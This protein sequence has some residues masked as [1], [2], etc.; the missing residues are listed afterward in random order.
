MAPRTFPETMSVF[1]I[2]FLGPFVATLTQSV[3]LSK[4]YSEDINMSLRASDGVAI[5]NLPEASCTNGVYDP[6][7]WKTLG[8][9][10]WLTDWYERLKPCPTGSNIDTRTCHIAGESWTTTFLRIAQNI[11]GGPG[12]TKLN[13]CLDN[14]PTSR[15]IF[16][17]DAVE[18]A[19]YRYVCYN[20]YGKSDTS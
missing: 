16:F 3:T 14:P 13:A 7:C 18:A 19:R 1:N 5:R 11:T 12:C 9:S 8:L 6:A 4:H 10:A 15:D 20:I 2:I 17:P